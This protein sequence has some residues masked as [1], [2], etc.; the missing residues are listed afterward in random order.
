MSNEV[1][2]GDRAH[3]A[4]MQ[5]I[6]RETVKYDKLIYCACIIKNHRL[7]YSSHREFY[8]RNRIEVRAI[9][10]KQGKCA[11]ALRLNLIVV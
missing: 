2:A 7:I 11:F 3:I 6:N 8:H 9:P 5:S 1:Y 4:Q 10:C